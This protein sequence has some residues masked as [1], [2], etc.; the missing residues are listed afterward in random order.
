MSD[1]PSALYYITRI[2]VKIFVACLG[3]VEII[4]KENIPA[5]GP[6]ILAPNHRAHVDPPYLTLCTKRQQFYMSKEELFKNPLFGRI[7]RG[8]G[9]FP[10]KRGSADRA[11]LRFAMDHLKRGNILTIFPEGTRSPDGALGEAENGFA[12]LAKQ[13][14]AAIVPIAVEGTERVLPYGGSKLRRARV[15]LTIGKPFTAE[16]VLAEAGKGKEGLE[17]IGKKVMAEIGKLM[18]IAG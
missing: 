5:T 18:R 4:G 1:R 9:A 15:R 2:G 14:G 6:V 13:T 3:G 12:L 7:I 8:L 16:D 10:V 11:A 17:A